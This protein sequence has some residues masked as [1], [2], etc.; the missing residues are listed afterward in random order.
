MLENIGAAKSGYPTIDY[1]S[2]GTYTS[3]FGEFRDGRE[4][5][6]RVPILRGDEQQ[7]GQCLSAMHA[8]GYSGGAIGDEGSDRAVVCAAVAESGSAG[9]EV[10]NASVAGSQGF[11]H[12][13][14]GGSQ[15]D[16][17]PAL[18]VGGE[19]E[20]VEPGIWTVLRLR[21]GDRCVR[22]FVPALQSI[23]IAAERG[24]CA[25]GFTAGDGGEAGSCSRRQRGTGNA[26][27]GGR[28]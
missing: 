3:S 28:F 25:F 24:G 16:D 14:I 26:A 4:P 19:G 1:S 13:A 18:A 6:A 8:G 7:T 9:D 15:S 27:S 17:Q 5:M 20:G 12:A 23:A 22:G 11:C 21:R 2:H 10:P